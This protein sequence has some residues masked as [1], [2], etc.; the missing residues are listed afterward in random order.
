M[1]IQ[2]R[3]R[4]WAWSFKHPNGKQVAELFLALDRPVQLELRSLDVIRRLFVPTFRI[5]E[6]VE[7]GKENYTWILPTQLGAFDIECTAIC[8]VSHANMLAKAV[9]GPVSHSKNDTSG[10]GTRRCRAGQKLRFPQQGR[11]K[12]LQSPSSDRDPA[13]HATQSTA[14]LCSAR[15]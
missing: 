1:T 7:S 8:G 5:K 10:T 13:W 4:Q 14:A 11:R 6:D 15:L 9:V 12:I 2:V 3:A